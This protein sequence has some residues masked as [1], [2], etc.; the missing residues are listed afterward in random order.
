[1]LE[2][3]GGEC[4]ARVKSVDSLLFSLKRVVGHCLMLSITSQN[5]ISNLNFTLKFNEL[6]SFRC[7]RN[8]CIC[9]ITIV[10]LST[11]PAKSQDLVVKK[12]TRHSHANQVNNVF[13]D[14]SRYPE[15]S[16]VSNV[17]KYR[18]SPRFM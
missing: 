11:R 18:L 5:N 16:T 4:Y 8:V 3:C 14:T 1:M 10:T 12:A 9:A 6:F 15:A 13:L 2:D 7:F 17:H